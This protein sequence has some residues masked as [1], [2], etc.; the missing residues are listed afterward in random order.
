MARPCLI[1]IFINYF[2]KEIKR[3]KRIAVSHDAA[4]CASMLLPV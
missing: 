3:K 4:F 2:L 1:L